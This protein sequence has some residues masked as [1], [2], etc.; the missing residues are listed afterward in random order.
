MAQAQASIHSS[1]HDLGDGRVTCVACLNAHKHTSGQV[2]PPLYNEDGTLKKSG[3]LLTVHFNACKSSRY[4]TEDPVKR[5]HKA[6]VCGN[7]KP[8]GKY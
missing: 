6:R 3:E 7:F 1:G 5:S 8:G 2:G 4:D